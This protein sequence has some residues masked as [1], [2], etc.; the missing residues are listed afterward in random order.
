MRTS[1]SI[2]QALMLVASWFA[3]SYR[4]CLCASC[5]AF[6]HGS[7]IGG[8]LKRF[9]S[10][11]LLTHRLSSWCWV[12]LGGY[13]YLCFDGRC[14]HS[15]ASVSNGGTLFTVHAR[16]KIT[17]LVL[18]IHTL[19]RVKVSIVSCLYGDPGSV[20]TRKSYYCYII[21]SISSFKRLVFVLDVRLI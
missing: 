14:N 3:L 5:L 20:A 4:L 11:C 7:V 8:A 19:H 12:C 13:W 15:W 16:V 17:P 10:V 9:L 2:F 1:L 6:C 21:N 18:F